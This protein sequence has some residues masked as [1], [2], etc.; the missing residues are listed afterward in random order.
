MTLREEVQF[1]EVINDDQVPR[2]AMAAVTEAFGRRNHQPSEKH[3]VGLR[4][5]CKAIEMMA[6]R[7]GDQPEWVAKYPEWEN[8]LFVSFL[9][10]GMGKTTTMTET[11]KAIMSF[12]KYDHIG[13]VIFLSKLDEIKKLVDEMKLRDNDFCVFT[14]DDELN[15]LGNPNLKQAR[16][17]FTTQQKLVSLCTKNNHKNFADIADYHYKGKPRQVRVWDEAILPSRILTLK[18][19]DLMTMIGKIAKIKV[20]LANIIDKFQVQLIDAKDGELVTIPDLSAY[21]YMLDEVKAVTADSGLQE[22]AEALFSLN[23]MRVRVCR[24]NLDS[25]MLQYVDILPDDIAPMLIL[26]ASGQQRKTYEYWQ[27]ERKGIK[28]L[29]SPEKNYTGFTVHHWDEG[30]GKSA[31]SKLRGK[32]R[33]LARGVARTIDGEVPLDKKCLVIHNKKSAIQPDMEIEISSQLAT[34]RDRVQYTTWGRHTATNDF[35]EFEYVILAGILQYSKADYEAHGLAAKGQGIERGLTPE[36]YDEIRLG[37]IAHNILQAA[38]RGKV[39]KA[40]GEGCPPGCH[41]YVIYSTQ[42]G[43]PGSELLGKVFPNSF[44]RAWKP[45]HTIA[46]KNQ[47]ALANLFLEVGPICTMLVKTAMKKVG[48]KNLTRFTATLENIKPYLEIEHGRIV[49]I[50]K[51]K[52]NVKPADGIPF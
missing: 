28:F 27:R 31:Q 17:M 7:L 11:I 5:I 32:Y 44:Y 12:E 9:P 46:G 34:D 13:F 21:V 18:R 26:D 36:E 45:V 42:G 50:I 52:L 24:D 23:G 43:V 15:R 35:S 37:E 38:C 49:E 2:A 4:Q 10:C 6:F 19:T 16:V 8:S 20:P 30:A 41:L 48:I 22:S 33:D 39:R 29:P 51:D 1:K 3:M 25:I 47:V 40:V 14:S